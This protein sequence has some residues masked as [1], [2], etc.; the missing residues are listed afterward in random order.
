MLLLLSPQVTCYSQKRG[1][2]WN[3]LDSMKNKM[4]WFLAWKN[5]AKCQMINGLNWWSIKLYRR[6][7][8]LCSLYTVLSLLFRSLKNM[9]ATMDGAKQYDVPSF[10]SHHSIQSYHHFKN[11]KKNYAFYG[12]LVHFRLFPFYYDDSRLPSK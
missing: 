12:I 10:K 4:K 3:L 1:K 8:L 7:H 5:S 6:K 9:H 2:N 11:W